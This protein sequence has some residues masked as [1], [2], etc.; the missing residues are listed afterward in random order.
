MGNKS[1]LVTPRNGELMIAATQ[2]F[3]TGGYLLTQKDTFFDRG[4]VCQIISQ[5]L[6]G[7]EKTMKID[8]PPP[9]IIKPIQLWT[10]K[11]IFSMML[12]PNKKCQVLANLVTKGKSYT[13]GEELCKQDSWV[14][15]RN[16]ELLSGSMDKSTLGSGSK[17]NIFYIL[18]RDFGQDVS[19]TAM[20]RISRIASWYL[21]NRGFSIGIGDVTPSKDLL[22]KKRELVQ[23]GY[24]KCNTY[25]QQLEDGGLQSQAGHSEDETLEALILKELSAIREKAG[26]ASLTALHR[27][28]APL[29]M[30]LCGS[31]GSNINISQ[32]IACVGQQAINGKRVPNGFEDRALPHFERHSKIPAAKGF[33]QNSF[34]S[35]LTPTEFFFHTMGGREGLVDTAVKTAE[36]GYMQRRLVKSLEDLVQQYDN[37]VR[38]SSNEV[39]QFEYGGD[40]LDPMMMEGKDKPVDFKRVLEHVKASSKYGEEEPITPETMV[41]SCE[42]LTKDML[43]PNKDFKKELN[44][45]VIK[46][47]EEVKSVQK[48]LKW[49]SDRKLLEVEKQVKRLT[50]SQMVEFT[51]ICKEKYMKSVMEP[52]TAVGALCAQSI[53]EPGTQMTLKTFHFAGVASMNITLGVP[54]IK[55]I[56]NASKKISTPIITVCLTNDKDTEFARRVKGR[57]EKTTLG[58][59]SEYIEEVFL[60]DNCFILVKL[61]IDRIKLLK[62]EVSAESIRYSL[63][64]SKVIKV[65]PSDCQVIGESM[66]TVKPSVS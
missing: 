50:L 59:V 37:T 30:A 44:E 17:T 49:D 51:D 31:K 35:G 63:C 48:R 10:G 66:I 9:A 36:T 24:D 64:N 65:K 14:I 52:G 4:K 38:N 15:I 43:G 8:L 60:P 16:S 5:I 45:F 22:C 29:T 23:F 34:Y 12:R 7:D 54:R 18:L 46:Y 19:C 25:I 20:W 2:D 33:V 27:S 1:N 57:I 21:M 61:D 58:E 62:L 11:Q 40:G 41:S 56:I 6:A 47:A 39:I 28:N 42:E 26:Q 53:G 55:E 13:S 32:M 3:I